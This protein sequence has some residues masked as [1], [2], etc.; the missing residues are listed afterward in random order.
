MVK[1]SIALS[2]FN[3]AS[4]FCIEFDDCALHLQPA[5]DLRTLDVLMLEDLA[6]YHCDLASVVSDKD[7]WGIREGIQFIYLLLQLE[8]DD[9]ALYTNATDMR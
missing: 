2:I 1:I 8:L 4:L 5:P 7:L 3:S 9:I 6:D